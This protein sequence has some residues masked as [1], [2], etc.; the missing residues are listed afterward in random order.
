MTLNRGVVNCASEAVYLNKY[1]KPKVSYKFVLN[2]QHTILKFVHTRIWM[3][4]IGLAVRFEAAYGSILVF[5]MA[6]F[7][8]LSIIL[9]NIFRK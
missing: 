3:I 7:M 8:P 4:S 5:A 9:D 1:T 2:F 6:D